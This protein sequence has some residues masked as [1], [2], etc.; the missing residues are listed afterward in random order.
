MCWLI[1]HFVIFPCDT[2]ANYL[3]V[4]V[5]LF[6]GMKSGFPL[7][8]M[9]ASCAECLDRMLIIRN[10]VSHCQTATRIAGYIS[11]RHPLENSKENTTN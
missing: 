11:L 3:T 1:M 8:M 6:S 5:V 10:L 9:C 2:S 4:G 7:R